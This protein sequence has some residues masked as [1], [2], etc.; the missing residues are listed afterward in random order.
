MFVGGAVCAASDSAYLDVCNDS[1]AL[2]AVSHR[3][4]SSWMSLSSCVQASVYCVSFF[5]TDKCCVL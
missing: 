2:A 4:L 5:V 3:D 1:D